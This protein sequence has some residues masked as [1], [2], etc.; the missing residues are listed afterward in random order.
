MVPNEVRNDPD[1]ALFTWPVGE[2]PEY[3]ALDSWSLDGW[4][5]I[6]KKHQNLRGKSPENPSISTS[7]V[8]FPLRRA[9]LPPGQG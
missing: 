7:D 9:A 3:M 2:P 6:Y 4:S 8:G 1:W 5:H